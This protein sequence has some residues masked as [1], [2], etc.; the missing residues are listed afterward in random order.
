[1]QLTLSVANNNNPTSITQCKSVNHYF[2]LAENVCQ[3]LCIT[4]M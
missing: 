1:M 2:S 3:N 4:K